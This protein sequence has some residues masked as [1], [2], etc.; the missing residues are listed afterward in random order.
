MKNASAAA[1][2]ILQSGRYLKQELWDI[3]LASGQ[4][5][6]FT[7]G[8]VPLPSVTLYLTTGAT[9]G[10]YSYKTGLALI[11]G[12]YTQKTGTDGGTMKLSVVPVL[13]PDIASVQPPVL[14]AGYPFLQACR[15][16]FLDG[17]LVRFSK[18][19]TNP[20]QT[21]SPMDTSPGASEFFDGTVEQIESG[22]FVA[23]LTLSDHL[24]YMNTQQMPRN[25]WMAGCG[26]KFLDAGCDPTGS[27][28]SASTFAGAIVAATDGA[29]FTTNLTQADHTFDLGY[30]TF[31][32]GANSGFSGTVTQFLH[33][34]GALIIRF[35]MP[36]APSAGDTFTIVE[37]CDLSIANCN[38]HSNLAHHS[39]TPFIP[40]PETVLDGGIENPP[41][42]TIGGQAGQ[43][44]ASNPTGAGVVSGQYRT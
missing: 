8:Q 23:E 41:A 27:V 37:G 26:H 12:D 13:S 44:I 1:L 6:H 42:Q 9:A 15:Y 28:R 22:R 31:T 29:H 32:S 19:F 7:G 14:I 35:P 20:P 39:G 4:T 18:L 5:Y 34:S 38:R 30:I 40:V 11:R 36:V 2:T 33:A 43:I 21:G 10:P 17:A 16:G 25:V 3:T 24:V